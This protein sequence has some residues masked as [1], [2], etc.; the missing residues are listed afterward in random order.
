MRRRMRVRN[1]RRK[2]ESGETDLLY[3]LVSARCVRHH[4]RYWSRVMTAGPRFLSVDSTCRLDCLRVCSSILCSLFKLNL[5]VEGRR[6]T[7]MDT[8]VAS[9]AVSNV[10][11]ARGGSK[12][13]FLTYTEEGLNSRFRLCVETVPCGPEKLWGGGE[14]ARNWRDAYFLQFCYLTSRINTSAVWSV[15]KT[16]RSEVCE[17][18]GCER[19]LGKN[20]GR[21]QAGV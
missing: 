4:R 20:L 1:S 3:V 5:R 8:L 12:E 21:G 13:V 17:K 9:R 7:V 15:E 18:V 19:V 2:A 16:G 10:A 11:D 6:A 14:G